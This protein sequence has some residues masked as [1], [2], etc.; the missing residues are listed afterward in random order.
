MTAM[1]GLVA[2]QGRDHGKASITQNTN[3]NLVEQ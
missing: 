2:I 3:D 1:S